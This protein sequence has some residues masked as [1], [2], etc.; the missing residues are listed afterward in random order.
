MTADRKWMK[1]VQEVSFFSVVKSNTYGFHGLMEMCVYLS[2]QLS[3]LVLN[4]KA[5]FLSN[6]L[7]DDGEAV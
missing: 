1:S 4:K 5:A 3:L 7:P 6:N 2:N